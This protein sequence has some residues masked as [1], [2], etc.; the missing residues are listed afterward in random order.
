M[1]SHAA[2]RRGIIALIAATAA[3]TINDATVKLVT[4]ALPTGEIIFIR[5]L[6][7]VICL[8]GALAA[9]G[10]LGKIT[11]LLNRWVAI[12]SLLDACAT[13]LFVTA[14][15]R[16]NLADLIS[17]ILASPLIMT[18][19]S[20]VL[21]NEKVGWRR[22]TA[23]AVGLVGT[24]FIVKPAPGSLDVWALLGLGTAFASASRDLITHRLSP[25]IP[26]LAIGTAACVAV[27]MA[28]ALIGLTEQWRV[29]NGNELAL[30]SG[31]AV[32]FSIGIYLLVK[33]FRGVEISVV[34]P[35]RYTLLLWGIVAG[36]VIL[37][38]V[39]DR[40]SFIGGALIVGSGIYTLH[41]EAVRRR[42]LTG[43]NPPQ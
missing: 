14:L 29:P 10:Q 32:F 2:N 42:D 23:I 7:T 39:P 18:A 24:L 26:S 37:G 36:Y 38:E 25:R 15:V 34:S 11:T 1:S 41:R 40:W 22:W 35:F 20:V 30:L 43:T 27:T 19:M 3:F 16:M 8:A 4:R 12:R 5:G 21:Y 33:A 13:T 31:T 17:I 6:M 9:M 28:G